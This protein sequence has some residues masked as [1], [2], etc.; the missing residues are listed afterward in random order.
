MSYNTEQ[1]KEIVRRYNKE[2]I[3]MGLAASF[4]ELL[5]DDVVNHSVDPGTPNGKESF[6]SFHNEVRK[7]FPDCK[8][9]ILEQVAENDLVVTRKRVT[10]THT[11]EILGIAPTNKPVEISVIDIVRVKDG[12]YREYWGHSNFVEVLR[13]LKSSR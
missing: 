8:V 3:E 13:R 1:N 7:G 5:A 12:K 4:E 2:C 6:T 10:G 9:E 11:G